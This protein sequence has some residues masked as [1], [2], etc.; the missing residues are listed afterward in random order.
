VRVASNGG[1]PARE[2]IAAAMVG[3]VGSYGLAATDIG[4]V[5]ERARTSR[6]H[7][8]RCFA[9]LEDCFL[10]LHEELLDELCERIEAARTG[11]ET[12]HDRVWAAG[13]A[14][15]RFLAMEPGRAR[16]LL[17][18]LDGAGRRAQARRDRVVEGL[19]ELLDGS[20]AKSA[21]RGVLSPCTSEIVAGA[22]YTALLA[23]IEDGSLERGEEF[24]PELVYLATAPYLGA[25]AAEEELRVQP[26]R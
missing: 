25:E 21:T 20:K 23:R 3:L 8:D 9:D 11:R 15:I 7:F 4:T 10:S 12:W 26:L 22:V 2:R 18:A 16:F 6:A 1:D 5:C 14:A 17:V 19:A 24:L 13:L